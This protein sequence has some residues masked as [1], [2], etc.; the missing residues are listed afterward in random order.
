MTGGENLANKYKQ[1]TK[2]ICKMTYLLAVF[3]AVMQHMNR[4]VAD[5]GIIID[6][7]LKFNSHIDSIVAKAHLRASL[8]RRCFVSKHPAI[9]TRAFKVYVRPLVEYAS[10]VWSPYY[11]CHRQGRISTTK[12]LTIWNTLPG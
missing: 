8:M 11:G 3:D 6:S 10:C 1:C 4:F 9:L 12:I 2:S 7:S 5:L